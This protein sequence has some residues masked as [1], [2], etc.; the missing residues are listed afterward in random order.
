MSDP[1]VPK[2][3]VVTVGLKSEAAL[4]PKGTRILVSGG[5]PARLAALLEALPGDVTGVLSF[6]IAG[7]L[8][9]NAATGDVFVATALRSL[10]ESL[11]VDPAWRAALVRRTSAASAILAASDTLLASVEAKRALH[12]ATR[13][14]AVDMESGV[15][16]RFAL[17]RGI[18]FAALRV[19]ADGP[20]DVLPGAAAVGLRPDG[21]P[22]PL[23][24]LAALARRPWELPALIRL[25]KASAAAHEA[26][27]RAIA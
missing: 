15:A 13:A 22:A 12:R 4:L 5:A 23:R 7:G 10:S 3:A 17:A 2:G 1:L 18:P 20:G 9:P 14:T 16:A 26:L 6:G 11:P 21:S 24:V 27:R 25:A 19:V 8:A